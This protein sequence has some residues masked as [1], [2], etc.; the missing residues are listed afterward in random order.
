MLVC[1]IGDPVK[2]F[3]LIASYPSAWRRTGTVVTRSYPPRSHETK[4]IQRLSTHMHCPPC[5]RLLHNVALSPVIKIVVSGWVSERVT[6]SHYPLLLREWVSRWVG[7]NVTDTKTVPFGTRPPSP[8]Q[9]HA[10]EPLIKTEFIH[11]SLLSHRCC[12]YY[13]YCSF[14]SLIAAAATTTTRNVCTGCFC[15]HGIIN[16]EIDRHVHV[17]VKTL[18]NRKSRVTLL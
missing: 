18:T 13:T 7:I 12:Y 11:S 2:C 15:H 10:L 17:P 6:T 4:R 3:L 9:E 16:H 5:R 8:R 14:V 1:G